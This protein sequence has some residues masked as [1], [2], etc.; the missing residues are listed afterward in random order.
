MHP[1]NG[2]LYVSDPQ[3]R[4]IIKVASL[5]SIRNVR[6][7]FEIAVGDKRQCLP[8]D[9]E[10]CGDG[11][12]AINAKLSRPKGNKKFLHIKVITSP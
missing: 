7:N 5:R 8:G 2:D 3:A 1:V 11:G 6:E 12:L 10:E 4:S 9:K